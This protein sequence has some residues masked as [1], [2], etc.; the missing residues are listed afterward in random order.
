MTIH[1]CL[2]FVQQFVPP[3]TPQKMVILFPPAYLL[4]VL[5]Q[6][7]SER[8]IRLG[9]QNMFWEEKGA[10]TG[11]LSPLM[12]RDCGCD[13]VILGH[14]ERRHVFGEDDLLINQKV[15]A[16]LT[17]GLIPILCIG[18]TLDDREMDATY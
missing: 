9:A 7:L 2:S 11:E 14:S 10:F 1:E 17:H 18:E 8:P 4:V 13:Y 15:K 12:L 16:A 5:F 6:A 3:A